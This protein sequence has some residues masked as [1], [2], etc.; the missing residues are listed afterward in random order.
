MNI[1][2]EDHDLVIDQMSL[3][4]P[5]PSIDILITVNLKR[6]RMINLV[7]SMRSDDGIAYAGIVFLS[8]CGLAKCSAL[9]RSAALISINTGLQNHHP[10]SRV[11]RLLSAKRLS[12]SGEI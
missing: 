2:A 10:R 11:Q 7:L 8:E 5:E 12:E 9:P 1:T 4:A 3:S 6:P